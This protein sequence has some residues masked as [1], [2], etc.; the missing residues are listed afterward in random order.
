MTNPQVCPTF[1]DFRELQ[2]MKALRLTRVARPQT[3]ALFAL[4]DQVAKIIRDAFPEPII[5]AVGMFL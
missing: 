1:F 3:E 2:R 5:T 4:P